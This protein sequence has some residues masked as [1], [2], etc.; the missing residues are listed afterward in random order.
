MRKGIALA[1]IAII[2]VIGAFY[3]V[4]EYNKDNAN[5]STSSLNGSSQAQGNANTDNETG[6]I[7]VSKDALKKAQDFKLKDLYGKDIS[8]SSLK[9]KNVLLNFWASWCPPCKAE[10]PDIEKL[11]QETK[12]TDVVILAVNLGED[13]DTVKLFIDKNKYNFN[14][15]LDTSQEVGATYNIAAIPSWFFIDKDGNL[16]TSHTG[17]MNLAQ[18]KSYVQLLENKK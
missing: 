18:M 13:K 8:L 7:N 15:L 1:V 3:T 10:M 12:G 14:I 11:Y 5:S 6:L 9:G 17:A 4:R 2:L 16:V